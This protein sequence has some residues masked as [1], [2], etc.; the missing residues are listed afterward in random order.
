MS[1]KRALLWCGVAGPV[2]FTAAYLLEGATRPGYDPVRDPV[3]SLALGEL[4]WTQTVNFL[5]TGAL[6]FAFAVGLW[7]DRGWG[8]AFPIL[9]G[10]V[11]VGF[12]GA[13]L[14]VTDPVTPYPPGSS[15]PDSPTTLGWLHD[16]FSL[17]VFF[18]L[19]AAMA[20]AGRRLGRS[21]HIGWRVCGIVSAILFLVF[22]LLASA[23]F[24]GEKDFALIGGFLQR[25][26]LTIGFAWIAALA[27]SECRRTQT[28]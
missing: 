6:L 15:I 20:R 17:G 8:K 14:F 5:V 21:R 18:G 4:G 7:L 3:S 9:M 1:M 10:I 26:C 22:F 24:T 27:F 13:G 19:P 11:A 12:F 23:G 2:F 28:P 25:V 16:L